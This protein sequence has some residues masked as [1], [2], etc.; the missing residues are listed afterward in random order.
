VRDLAITASVSDL[1]RASDGIDCYHR[2][3]LWKHLVAV[4]VCARMVAV[5]TGVAGFE[6]AFLSGLLHDVGIILID[7][8]CHQ[9]FRSVILGLGSSTTLPEAERK[10]LGW[11]HTMLGHEVG[12]KWNFPQTVLASIRFH[13]QP[14]DCPPEHAEMVHCVAIANLLCSIKDMTSVG[15]NL[16]QLPR[17]SL[18]ARNLDK[19]DLK[20]LAADLDEEIRRH[21][22]LFDFH[23][24]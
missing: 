9:E 8:T 5:R 15:R 1:F 18:A 19:S 11:D 6:N 3:G 2:P 14:A 7:Q 13:H 12:V 10:H 21:Q 23:R 4:G 16:I 22:H 17:E 20:I 24:G